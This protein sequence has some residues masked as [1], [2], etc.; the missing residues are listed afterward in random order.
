M[1]E[2]RSFTTSFLTAYN[3]KG[4]SELQKQLKELKNE[5]SGNK[6]EQKSLS[7]EIRDAEKEVKKIQLQI[8]KTGEATKEQNDRLD[9]LNATIKTNKDALEKLKV[10]QAQLQS[11]INETNKRIEKQKTAMQQLTKSMSDAKGHA[12][13][14]AK[15]IATVAGAG[16]AATA[17]IFAFTKDA[18]QWADDMNTLSKTTGISTAELQ[19]FAYATNLVDVSMDTLT[20]SLT[21]LTRNMAD[22]SKTAAE[23]FDTLKIKTRDA[24]D[25][26]RDRQE[27]FYEIID[28]LGK[29]GNETKR[30]ALA[31]DIFGES[32]Q[33]LNPLIKGGA[34]RLKELGDEAERAGLIL[35]QETLDGLNE[36][37]DKVDELKAKGDAI[38]HLAA[39]EMTPA[40]D[41][42][43]EVAEELLDEIKEAAKSGELKKTAKEIGSMIKTGA[44][45]LK[46]LIGFVWK[47]KEAVA[48]AVVGMV[49]F[50]V[51]MS[52]SGL[53]VTLSAGLKQL[54]TVLT[55]EK[56]ATEGATVAH[57]GFNATLAAN[58]ILAVI[59]LVASLTVA[60]ASYSAM[61]GKS[62]GETK[63]LR[64]ETENYTKAIDDAR[65][66]TQDRIASAEAEAKYLSELTAEYDKLRSSA[67]LTE[68]EKTRLNTVAEELAKTLGK[69]TQELKDKDG[70][71]KSLTSDVDLYLK[72]L[73]EQ[74]LWESHK[75]EYTAAV[76]AQE[77][78]QKK[79]DEVKKKWDEVVAEAENKWIDFETYAKTY[80]EIGYSYWESAVEYEK[81]H[82]SFADNFHKLGIEYITYK[83][84]LNA[85]NKA[86]AKAEAALKSYSGTISGTGDDLETLSTKISEAKT[87]FSELSKE[88]ETL[89]KESSSLRSEMNSLANSMKSLEQGETLSYNTLLDL[90]DKYPEYASELVNAAGNADLQRAALEKLFEAKKQE[91]ILSQQAALDKIQASNNETQKIISN[92]R[93]QV[94]AYAELEKAKQTAFGVYRTAPNPGVIDAL[95]ELADLEK[96]VEDGKKIASDY[97][98][99]INLVSGLKIGDF[100]SSG[101]SSGNNSGRSSSNSSAKKTV[102]EEL[103][104]RQKLALAA[105]N[106][107]VQNKI[108]R[109]NAEAD[110]AKKSADAQIA[111]IDAVMKKRSEDKEDEKRQQELAK[112]DARL[113]YEHLD[114]FSRIELER[115]KQ[116]ILNEQADVDYTRQMEKKKTGISNYASG[117]SAKN[118]Q[119]IA[120]LNAS[121]TQFAD[122]MAYIQGN[123]TYDQR[124]ANNSTSNNVTIVQNGMNGD[125]VLAKLLKAL[126]V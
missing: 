9:E 86:V 109:L 52:I 95:K 98:S 116:D 32:A 75:E 53:V 70:V 71:Y 124:V 8:D 21:K 125:Q 18:A 3:N 89:Q 58:P 83:G 99:K 97:Q 66:S 37:N 111:A 39:S 57:A 65:K 90:I 2:G 77:E 56:V 12:A 49:A 60:L 72:K 35:S 117:I 23:A 59:S 121:K 63:K 81:L 42:L 104:D 55:A 123:Q 20:G 50:K 91:Y 101:G 16:A 115:R 45:A 5:M 105:Y 113:K 10:E 46:N 79:F 102:D 14:L 48:G 44:A 15:T 103:L 6:R 67:S 54:K 107:L 47:Y 61:A 19:K 96:Q 11:Q 69:T 26:L 126:G 51:S 33:E 119:A 40:L 87:K 28:A 24:T 100:V 74:A 94:E 29:V 88:E 106:K 118:Q 80:S 7:N 13:D 93:R 82:K 73:K 92:L 36:F 22:P 78:A 84:Q 68:A 112:I 64:V 25:E 120:G 41:G 62:T 43:L 27:V 38:K 1:A 114:E 110:A 30:D 85:A 76:K 122:R 17:G 31:V 34:E 4:I 108:D